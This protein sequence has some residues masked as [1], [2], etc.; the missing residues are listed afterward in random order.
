MIPLPDI[1]LHTK[2]TN[3][4]IN[5]CRQTDGSLIYSIAA[6]LKT[7]NINADRKKN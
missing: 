7:M 2:E 4:E 1:R 3:S 5:L 6:H